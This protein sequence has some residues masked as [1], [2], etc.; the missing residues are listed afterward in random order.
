MQFLI[1]NSAIIL[2]VVAVIF[3]A[4]GIV[5]RRILPI[6]IAIAVLISMAIV[7]PIVI[8]NVKT[9]VTNFFMGGIDPLKDEDYKDVTD[10]LQGFEEKVEPEKQ[11][12]IF[13]RQ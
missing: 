5:K 11:P 2:F 8:E 6:L 4:L 7:Q 10:G 9:T 12:D 1:D 13:T 3:F